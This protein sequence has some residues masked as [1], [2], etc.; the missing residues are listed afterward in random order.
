M[1][2]TETVYDPTTG[3]ST[4]VPVRR[5]RKVVVRQ[6]PGG[7]EAEI[8]PTF[9]RGTRFGIIDRAEPTN[10]QIRKHN[11]GIFAQAIQ[12]RAERLA[13]AV[14]GLMPGQS[15]FDFMRRTRAEPEPVEEE[16]PWRQLIRHP[17]PTWPAF[18]FWRW[19]Q[20]VRD[21]LGHSEAV[22]ERDGAGMPVALWPVN[23]EWGRVKKVLDEKGA[24][25][26]YE[27]DS[28]QGA[29]SKAIDLENLLR[30]E[31]PDPVDGGGTSSLLERGVYALTSELES[32]KYEKTFMEDGRPPNVYIKMEGTGELA[33]ADRQGD[34]E[35][36]ERMKQG[37]MGSRAN[38]VPVLKNADFQSIGLNPEELQML[39]ARE[40]RKD[41]IFTIT[42]TPPALFAKDPTNANVRAAEKIFAK[43]T[44]Q[45]MAISTASEV[46]LQ[47][48]QIFRA[49]EGM[50]QIQAPNMVPVDKAEQEEIN[51]SRVSR[52][53]PPAQI[54]E[55]QGEEIPEGHEEELRQSYI[56]NSLVPIGRAGMGDG[57]PPMGEESRDFL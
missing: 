42:G 8:V 45:P 19:M 29:G 37:Y 5:D 32:K 15:G 23:P 54:M 41:E 47:F 46:R 18:L 52:G 14:T 25:V 35:E 33:V 7:G 31:H 20:Q 36:G 39:G 24:T 4:E 12:L 16:H 9:S 53:V 22:V 3:T 50:L 2:D 38:E 17:N 34:K 1:P 49:D 10:P 40:M 57:G 21:F 26:R 51:Q 30:I 28:Y 56:P 11:V 27:Y 43:V 48:E 6:N 55:E 13:G 44:L